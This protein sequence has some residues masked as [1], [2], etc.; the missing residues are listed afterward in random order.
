MTTHDE[1]GAHD[2]MYDCLIAINRDAFA[3]GSY[4]TAYHALA[5][6]LH[7]AQDLGADSLLVA[8]ARLAGEQGAYIDTHVPA[9]SL[10]SA[11]AARR[12]QHKS[13]YAALADQAAMR[14]RLVRFEHEQDG[15]EGAP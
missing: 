3:A 11:S 9:H 7:R 4:E 6:A 2:R 13:I 15:H 12:G 14:G 1:L 8:V 5:S 10:S